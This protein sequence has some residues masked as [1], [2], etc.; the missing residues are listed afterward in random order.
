MVVL[1]DVYVHYIYVYVCLYLYI[2]NGHKTFSALFPC[3]RFG[4]RHVILWL[5]LKNLLV[6]A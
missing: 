2:I 1:V 5:T 6:K 4:T 3:E